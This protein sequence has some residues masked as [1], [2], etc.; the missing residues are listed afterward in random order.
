[1]IFWR[2]KIMVSKLIIV[3]NC[4]EC[5]FYFKDKSIL[6]LDGCRKL[7]LF[8]NKTE[9]FKNC[10]LPDDNTLK[11]ID[12]NESTLSNKEI[13]KVL[14]NKEIYKVEPEGKVFRR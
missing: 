2:E 10:P 6:K 8:G 11:K 1:M 5:I 3:D 9:L 12:Q 14:R 13:D 4:D 7:N